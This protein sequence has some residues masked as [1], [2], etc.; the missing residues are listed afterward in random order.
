MP[1]Y[2]AFSTAAQEELAHAVHARLQNQTCDHLPV[3]T[4]QKAQEIVRA[5]QRADR[6]SARKLLQ[7]MYHCC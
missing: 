7:A 2:S 6:A 5:M 1:T 4:R 3:D